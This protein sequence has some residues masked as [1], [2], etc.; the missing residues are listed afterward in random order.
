MI[1]PTRTTCSEEKYISVDIEASGPIPG[2]YSMLALGACTIGETPNSFYR[3]L[4]P[5]TDNY[6]SEAMKVNKLSLEKLSRDGQ[7]PKV[8]M[9][10]FKEWIELQSNGNAAVFVG[11]NA[12]FDW[13]FVN[14]YFHTYLGENPF[15]IAALDIKAYYMG[16]IG[17][18]WSQTKAKEI[19]DKYQ[20]DIK[21]THNALDDARA[22][23][24]I[25][26]KLL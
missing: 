26:S 3:E 16:K 19:I 14:W 22:Q 9:L 7:Q 20:I 23:A 21:Q 18:K 11:F 13:Q 24:C 10:E 4:K 25:F 2:K 6:V 15:G 8:V 17:C 1:E 5:I 12:G